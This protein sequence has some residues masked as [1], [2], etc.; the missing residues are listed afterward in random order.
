MPRWLT[1]ILF[2]DLEQVTV[3]GGSGS[4]LQNEDLGENLLGD[5]STSEIWC[6][7]K[8]FFLKKKKTSRS[9]AISLFGKLQANLCHFPR[10]TLCLPGVCEGRGERDKE[11][12]F[13]FHSSAAPHGPTHLTHISS[14]PETGRL[15]RKPGP[16]PLAAVRLGRRESLSCFSTRWLRQVVPSPS[17]SASFRSLLRY[18]EL[19]AS[20]GPNKS[21][22]AF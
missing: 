10:W 12:S 13:T 20:P 3:L 16:Y 8:V 6:W 18:A 11:V 21:E 7:I 15:R 5:L 17:A 14:R 9:S 4:L 1:S 19:W 2:G 22:Y